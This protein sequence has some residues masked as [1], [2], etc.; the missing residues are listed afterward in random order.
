MEGVPYVYGGDSPS[1]FDCSGLIYWA[2]LQLGINSMP[3]DTFE[4]LSQGVS[5]GLLVQT[6]SPSYGD[7]AFFGTGHVE[8]YVKDGETFGAQ[9]TGTNVGYHPY[10]PGYGPT[11][12]YRVS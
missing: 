4:M 10:G 7:L 6:S 1:G 12:F 2:A 11:A 5:Y 8:L 3:R 9:H